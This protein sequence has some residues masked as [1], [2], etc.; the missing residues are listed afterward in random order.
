MDTKKKFDRMTEKL[1]EKIESGKDEQ[2]IKPWKSELPRNYVSG[3]SYSGSNILFLWDEAAEKEYNTNE[4]LTFNQVKKLGA[5]VKKGEKATPIF[6]F[7]PYE[8][9]EE[10]KETGEIISKTVPILKVYNVFNIDQTTIEVKTDRKKPQKRPKPKVEEFI[11]NTR[12]TIKNAPYAY[13]SPSTDR[14]GIPSIDKFFSKDHYYSTLLHELAHWTGHSTRLNRDMSGKFGSEKYAFEELI[15][16]TAS[17]FLNVELGIDWQ[18]M[19]HVE[20][21]KHWIR[22][23][24][25]DSK[26]LW[27]AASQAQKIVDYLKSLQNVS[28]VSD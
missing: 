15:A 14:I 7:K 3:K 19:Q 25:K 9:Q 26:I 27:K 18:K 2:W 21:L 22:I 1:I 24:K 8:I 4:W 6:F 23:I 17:C 10:N 11:V 13:Y 20:Y 28:G 16:E 12:A 5:S